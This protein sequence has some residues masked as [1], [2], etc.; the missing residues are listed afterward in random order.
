MAAIIEQPFVAAEPAA[1][2][3][4]LLRLVALWLAIF[5]ALAAAVGGGALT[6]RSVGLGIEHITTWNRNAAMPL[7]FPLGHALDGDSIAEWQWQWLESQTQVADD[8]AL[9]RPG[10]FAYRNHGD[11]VTTAAPRRPEGPQSWGSLMSGNFPGFVE[12]PLIAAAAQSL[13]GI[14]VFAGSALALVLAWQLRKRTA[15]AAW[16]PRLTRATG[17][18]MLAASLL[19]LPA[20]PVVHGFLQY[21]ASVAAGSPFQWGST[22]LVINGTPWSGLPTLESLLAMLGTGTGLLLLA[23]MFRQGERLRRDTAGLV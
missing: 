4:P 16:L 13:L 18:A 21:H 12:I 6:I 17:G 8:L 23:A 22:D 7:P 20:L 14:G 5:G 2:R 10:A 9:R 15:F 19:A 1:P 3:P 11:L